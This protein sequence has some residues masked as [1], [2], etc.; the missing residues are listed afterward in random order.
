MEAKEDRK[1]KAAST[2]GKGK[3]KDR[4]KAPKESKA[5]ASGQGAGKSA[6]GPAGNQGKPVAPD[7]LNNP[8][9]KGRGL[10]TGHQEEE[11]PAARLKTI[12]RG[13]CSRQ[14]MPDS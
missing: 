3:K 5:G 1:N 13:E 6:A 11:E 10:I 8:E 14:K 7:L 4:K 2:R 12:Q 9:A